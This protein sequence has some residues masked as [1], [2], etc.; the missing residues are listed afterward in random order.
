MAHAPTIYQ[1]STAY[2][3]PSPRPVVAIGNFDGVH[4]GH[5]ALLRR[6]VGQAQAMG[7]PAL[8][9]TFDPSPAE[10]LRPKT[11]K[12][13]LQTLGDR[14]SELGKVGID[15]VLLEPFTADF[16]KHNAHW[17]A[18]QVLAGALAASAVVIGWD[19]RFGHGRVGTAA[20]LAQWLSVPVHQIDAVSRFGEPISSTAVRGALA[21]GRV[22]TARSLLGRSHQVVGVVVAGD[23]LGRTLGFPTANI[24]SE[25]PLLPSKGVYAV[26]VDTP[27]RARVPGVAN[28]GTRPTFGGKCLALEV[29]LLHT[30]PQLYG[31]RLRVYFE[32][33]IRDEQSFPNQKTLIHQ[34]QQDISV[35]QT[36]LGGVYGTG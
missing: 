34:I 12:P 27:T 8:A 18:T 33:R 30:S 16:A 22:D 3:Q 24:Q 7:V 28:I 20:A 14:L 2:P 21:K 35:A 36:V 5:R 9:Y 10:V 32:A 25:T 26:W 31:Q 11:A 15:Q 19:F 6:A 1:G 23:R 4:L 29:H 17:F 13:R